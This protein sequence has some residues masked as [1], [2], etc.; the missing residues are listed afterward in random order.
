M[1]F[2]VEI[3]REIK[4]F[5]LLEMNGVLFEKLRGFEMTLKIHLYYRLLR[6]DR[7]DIFYKIMAYYKSANYM[8]EIAHTRVGMDDLYFAR[9]DIADDD[10]IWVL[11]EEDADIA[12]KSVTSL[13]KLEYIFSNFEK[14]STK[15][16]LESINDL[17]GMSVSY[18]YGIENFI[19][20]NYYFLHAA[21]KKRKAG[22]IEYIWE[23]EESDIPKIQ[24]LTQNISVIEKENR[25][26]VVNYKSENIN[27]L[28]ANKI[29][30][31]SMDTLTSN[32][33]FSRLL[34]FLG[35]PIVN[36][37]SQTTSGGFGHSR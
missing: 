33:G 26:F 21:R 10:N 34:D 17:A 19:E 3:W 2:P 24:L 4:G 25:L 11:L 23:V 18:Y 22:H 14:M 15:K 6:T 9:N 37:Y 16:L 28:K 7:V 12:Y 20:S 27:F 31:L 35:F 36:I 5:L 1:Y 13:R 32:V 29:G 8:L 30:K